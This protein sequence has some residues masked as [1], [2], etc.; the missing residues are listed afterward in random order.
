ML[1]YVKSA[2]KKQYTVLDLENIVTIVSKRSFTERVAV[3]VKK[4]HLM[5]AKVKK[6]IVTVA[7][8]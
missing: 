8:P 2:V 1:T 6:H 7:Q 3:A 4:L 5:L